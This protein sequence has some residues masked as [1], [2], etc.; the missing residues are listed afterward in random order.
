[1]T[2]QFDE[3]LGDYLSKGRRLKGIHTDLLSELW[4]CLSKSI[5]FGFS[6]DTS[7]RVLELMLD[8]EAELQLR[9]LGPDS[10]PSQH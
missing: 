10:K 5:S 1:V 7:E 3:L 9:G 2:A 6:D 8:I 4:S